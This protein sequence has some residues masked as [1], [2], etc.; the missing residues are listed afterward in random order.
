MAIYRLILGF[1]LGAILGSFSGMLS[2]RLPKSLS[3]KGRSYCPHCKRS[4]S[5][6]MLLP[7]LSFIGLKGRCFFCKSPI[8]IHYFLSELSLALWAL[9]GLFGMPFHS[10]MFG[11]WLVFGFLSITCFFTDLHDLYLPLPL[12]LGLI[13]S[14]LCFAALSGTFMAHAVAAVLSGLVFMLIQRL[15]RWYYKQD[16]IGTGDGLL[17]MGITAHYGGSFLVPILYLSSLMG[18]L[19]SL[20]LLLIQKKSKSTRIPFGSLLCVAALICVAYYGTVA[21]TLFW[22]S[23][24][25]S[26]SSTPHL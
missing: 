12:T 26:S 24:A 7:L 22:L 1:S 16:S 6:W 3:L 14:G 21:K 4:L 5:W 13:A 19:L 18:G 17:I 10:F 25:L 2:V 15:A 20:Y 9:L 11:Q 8:S 23:A